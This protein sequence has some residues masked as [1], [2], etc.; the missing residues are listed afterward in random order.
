MGWFTQWFGFIHSPAIRRFI[1]RLNRLLREYLPLT[2]S[3][4]HGDPSRPWNRFSIDLQDADGNEIFAYQGNW[5]DIFQNWE[6]LLQGYPCYYPSAIHRFLNTSSADGYNPYRIS[7]DGFEW[8]E[9]NP[10]DPWANIG[11]WGDHQIVYLLRLLEPASRYLGNWWSDHLESAV[12]VYSDIPYRIG[13]FDKRIANPRETIGFD[14]EHAERIRQRVAAKGTDGKLLHSGSDLVRVNLIEKLCVPVLA[15]MGNFV[16]GAG[17]WMNTQRPEWNDANNALVGYGVSL[18]TA[19]YLFRYARFIRKTFAASI[20][21]NTF[22]LS[23]P[24][25][26]W[27]QQQSNLFSVMPKSIDDSE[28]L[29][30]MRSLAAITDAFHGKLY[31]GQLTEEKMALSGD[32]VLTWLEQIENLL[33]GT[34]RENRRSDGL[35]HSYNLL[36]FDPDSVAIK[37][38]QLM[39]EGQV[40]ILSSGLLSP[41]ESL[42]IYSALRKSDLY[43]SDQHSYLLYPNRQLPG[44]LQKNKIPAEMVATCGDW[45]QLADNGTTRILRPSPDGVFY[46]F[47]ADLRNANDLRSRLTSDHAN[48][49]SK[50]H[51]MLIDLFEDSFN[52]HAF[53]GRSGTFYAYEGLGSIYWHMVSKLALAVLEEAVANHENGDTFHFQKLLTAYRD[54]KSGLGVDKSVTTHGAI[55]TDAYSHT[56]GHAGA[57]QPG[58]TGQVKEDILCRLL[59][60]G[61]FVRAGRLSFV[62]GFFDKE[63][64][65]LM[66]PAECQ[67]VHVNGSAE[68]IMLDSGS[69]LFSCCQI[70]IIYRSAGF[71]KSNITVHYFNGN[72]VTID[73]TELPFNISEEVFQRRGLVSRIEVSFA[74]F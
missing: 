21:G 43:R 13:A 49:T 54:I 34:L 25:A 37:H 3:R 58:M 60:W 17:I 71:S 42:Q 5:R 32:S 65:L 15:K 61:V 24:V 72:K 55:P 62:D 10:E 68:S 31:S 51:Q 7:K 57:Q 30:V 41:D 40:S 28:R 18:V 6:A 23:A 47:A 45:K 4:R 39:L 48:R 73:D 14:F 33:A 26:Q 38:L 11:Y 22:E 53:T 46:A 70:P 1:P 12:Y 52:H 59:E 56:P 74:N 2:F 27:L 9:P 20:S 29:Q 44:F 63:R 16:P 19:G 66:E 50:E 67:F 8:E 64:E 69:C 35:Y 36:K